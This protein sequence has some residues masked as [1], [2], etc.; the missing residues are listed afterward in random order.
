M[1]FCDNT[2]LLAL[3]KSHTEILYNYLVA[4]ARELAPDSSA[5]GLRRSDAFS[6]PYLPFDKSAARCTDLSNL[7]TE[8]Q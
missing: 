3:G 6:A 8:A 7:Y 1:F 2:T 4:G 5:T